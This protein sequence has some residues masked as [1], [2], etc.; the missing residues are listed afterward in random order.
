MTF[1]DDNPFDLSK[2]SLTD[3][4]ASGHAFAIPWIERIQPVLSGFQSAR[5][6][7]K[8]GPWVH[9]SPFDEQ[10]V[11]AC[12]MVFESNGGSCTYRDAMSSAAHGNSE[13]MSV[14]GS[15]SVG[16]PFLKAEASGQYDKSVS[17]NENV[18]FSLSSVLL[19]RDV[20]G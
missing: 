8:A 14:S 18:S 15:L 1:E 20:L 5:I 19:W 6:M 17:E 9:A 12:N 13:H 4:A 7:D 16:P 3:F 11:Q 2:P 10:A